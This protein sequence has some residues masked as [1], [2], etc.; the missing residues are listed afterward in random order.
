MGWSAIHAIA[1]AKHFGLW[2]PV[3]EAFIADFGAQLVANYDAR[4]N[5][6]ELLYPVLNRYPVT[7]PGSAT[8][9]SEELTMTLELAAQIPLP[10]SGLPTLPERARPP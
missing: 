5:G 8:P 7:R 10:R 2:T 9:T 3:Q 1:E 6:Q 4:A